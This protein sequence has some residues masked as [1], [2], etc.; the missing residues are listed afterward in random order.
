MLLLM[1]QA[2]IVLDTPYIESLDE[3]VERC[4][5]RKGLKFYSAISFLCQQR[6]ETVSCRRSALN[7]FTIQFSIHF[8]RTWYAIASQAVTIAVL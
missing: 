4:A 7:I 6:K 3:V 2:H 5:R 8:M 1:Y